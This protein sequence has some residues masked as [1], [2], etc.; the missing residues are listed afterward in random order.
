MHIVGHSHDPYHQL[1]RVPATCPTMNVNP[2]VG[3]RGNVV[4]SV[5]AFANGTERNVP[6]EAA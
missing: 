5:R 4:R 6:L 1:L 2:R 3:T